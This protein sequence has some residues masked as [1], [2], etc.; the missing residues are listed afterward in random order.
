LRSE[1]RTQA[2]QEENLIHNGHSGFVEKP[3]CGRTIEIL[4]AGA[5]DIGLSEDC[6]LQDDDV[7]HIAAGQDE[8]RAE[9]DDFGDFAQKSDKVIDA[10]FRQTVKLP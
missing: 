10:R 7:A 3:G 2:P 8:K 6:R 1:S 9:R 5:E 4:I